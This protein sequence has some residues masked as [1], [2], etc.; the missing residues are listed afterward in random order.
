MVQTGT[1]W[2]DNALSTPTW[3]HR[4]I[5]RTLNVFLSVEPYRTTKGSFWETGLTFR[6]DGEPSFHKLIYIF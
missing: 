3:P 6:F 1:S 2:C 4:G 5:A